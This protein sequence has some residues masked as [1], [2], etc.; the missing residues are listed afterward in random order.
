MFL[1]LFL[2]LVM[3]GSI[4]MLAFVVNASD[5]FSRTQLGEE[6]LHVGKAMFYAAIAQL[7]GFGCIA[8][9]VLRFFGYIR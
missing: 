8:V 1:V 6:P 7:S 4:S 3:I 5:N 9:I 2:V